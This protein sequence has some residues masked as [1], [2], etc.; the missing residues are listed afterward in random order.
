[1]DRQEKL[2][3]YTRAKKAY[4]DGEGIMSDLEFDALEKELGLEN[5]APVGTSRNPSYTVKHP[6]IMGSLSKVQVK[7]HDGSVD[8]AGFLG[9]VKSY[10]DR[11]GE[12][13]PLIV[14]PERTAT[15][16]SGRG[17]PS[18]TAACPMP[19]RGERRFRS[20]S[21]ASALSGET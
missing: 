3:L 16:T 6:C 14:T 7:E 13:V 18:R 17:S 9:E 11:A 2:D 20:T 15:D 12:D 19:T 21:T 1:M 10:L 8:W 4:Y 5:R